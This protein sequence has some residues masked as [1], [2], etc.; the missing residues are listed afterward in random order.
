MNSVGNGI[1]HVCI[2][3]KYEPA[4]T[5]YGFNYP[6]IMYTCDGNVGGQVDWMGPTR[7]NDDLSDLRN[8]YGQKIHILTRCPD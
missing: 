8:T 2:F 1:A 6:A 3:Q 5:A 4:Y 7:L